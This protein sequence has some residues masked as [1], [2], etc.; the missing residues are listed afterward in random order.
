MSTMTSVDR[1]LLELL[2]CPATGENLRSEGRGLVSESGRR[3]PVVQGVPVLFVEEDL[4]PFPAATK[5]SDQAKR[6]LAGEPLPDD[7]F[8]ETVGISDAERR[9]VEARWRARS[10]RIDPVV[11][12]LLAATGGRAFRDPRRRL[13]SYPIPEFPGPAGRGEL[14]LDVGSGW[15]RWCFAAERAGWSPV[16]IDPSLGA[17]LAARRVAREIGSR[18][19]FVVGD[20]RCLPFRSGAFRHAYSFSVLQHFSDE[21][22]RR[23]VVALAGVVAPAAE[24]QIQMAGLLGPL[25]LLARFR[26]GFRSPREFEVRY[27]SPGRL[28]RLF[29]PLGAI[30]IEVDAFLGL[31]LR[32]SDRAFYGSPA[33][34]ALD[35]SEVLRRMVG[36]TGSASWIADSLWVRFRRQVPVADG[37][38]TSAPTPETKKLSVS[39]T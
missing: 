33:R 7:G 6:V 2:R 15:G 34:F 32:P 13:E 35:A 1:N 36:R 3:F 10:S 28:R 26:R 37:A 30:R 11:E 25:G 17:V 18:A 16:G 19:Q 24:G 27:R 39:S 5:S 12:A 29:T 23:T 4:P 22:V 9:E 20:G 31:G 21:D 14:L 38:R 8:L